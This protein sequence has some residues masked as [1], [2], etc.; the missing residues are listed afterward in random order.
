[1]GVRFDLFKGEADVHELIGPMIE[2]LSHDG[3]AVEDTGAL[4]MFVAEESDAVEVPPLILQKSDGGVMYGTTDLATIVDRVNR[5][6]PDAMLY[7][8]DQ[9][10][11]M[12][13][14]QVFRAARKTGYGGKA[15]LEHIGF[16]TMN[17]TDGKPFKTRAGG[18]MKLQDLIAMARDEA[19][20]RLEEAGLA[21][22]YPEEERAEIARMVGV[23][24]VKFADLANHRMSNYIFD[25]D[26]FHA[27]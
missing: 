1:M 12:H 13:F 7:V 2:T 24:A 23:A 14:E 20:R 21:A 27:V 9:R 19:L 16:G 8:V 11:H 3:H 17:G 6:D 26:R 5:Y 4:V 18:V 15:T 25:L 22:G 10:Q